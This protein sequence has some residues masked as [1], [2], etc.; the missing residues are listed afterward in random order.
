[1]GKHIICC[2]T[3]LSLCVMKYLT[4]AICVQFVL[5]AMVFASSITIGD[6]APNFEVYSTNTSP[7]HSSSLKGNVLVITYE[8]KDVVDKNKAFKDKVLELYSTDD[9]MS[10][11]VRIIPIINCFKY[12]WPFKKYCIKKT[13]ENARSLGIRLY[14]DKSGK[15]YDDFGMKDDESNVFVVDK[16]G[17][18][19]YFKEGQ[20]NDN[21]IDQVMKL[22]HK[23]ATH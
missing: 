12:V 18:V 5:A 22:I 10:Q 21:E 4:V 13:L 16:N 23:L 7:L 6:A 11:S 8:T 17:I 15:M 1:M 14:Y 3:R 2:Q 20:L 19:S 9:S